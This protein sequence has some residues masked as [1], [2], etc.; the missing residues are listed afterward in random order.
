MSTAEIVARLTAD[1][2]LRRP[3]GD[4]FELVDGALVEINM[5]AESSLVGAKLA[6]LLQSFIDG[7]QSGFVFGADCGIQCFEDDPDK[8]RKPDVTFV[9]KGRLPGDEIPKGYLQIVPDLAA[10]VVSPRDEMYEISRKAEEYLAAGIPL[11]WIIN[12]HNRTVLVYR[13]DGTIL[14]LREKDELSG[15]GIL[16]GFRCRVGDLFASPGAPQN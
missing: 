8:V 12:P 5:G 13:V 14:G 1:D 16:P 4:R 6:H 2:L 10:E 7:R 9:R 11:V 3:D 15:E